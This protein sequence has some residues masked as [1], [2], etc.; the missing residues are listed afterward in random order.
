MKS[1]VSLTV[2]C[3]L[4]TAAFGGFCL[5]QDAGNAPVRMK[6]LILSTDGS[7]PGV[8]AM[9]YL[10]DRLGTPYDL[11][12]LTQRP[13][14]PLE[15]GDVGLYQGIILATGNLGVCDPNCHSALTV[16]QWAGMDAYM[17]KY[18]VRAV[19]YFTW[20]ELRYGLTFTGAQYYTSASP[21]MAKFTDAAGSVFSDLRRNQ[22]VEI[23][24]AYVYRA[25]P[26]AMEGETT[27]PILTLGNDVLAVVH[28]ANNGKR[29]YLALTFDNN[30]YLYHSQLLHYGLINWVT[31]G[32]FLGER[33]AYLTPQTD[34]FFLPNDLFDKDVPEC[35]PVGFATDPTFD[36]APYCETWRMTNADLEELYSWQQRKRRSSQFSDF[37]I[38]LAFN[39]F[40]TTE[41]GG[42]TKNDVL[43]AAA[44]KHAGDFYWI[45]HTY[46]HESLDC[47]DAT[48]GQPCRPAT[49][50]ESTFEIAQNFQIGDQVGL[51]MDRSSMVTPAI[52][53][54]ANPDFLAAARDQGLRYL[55]SDL[56]RPEGQ[57]TQPNTAIVSP[58]EPSIVYIPRH[59][60]N[61]YY[62]V[63][64]SKTNT[65]GSITDEYNFF[66]GPNGY[67]KLPDGSP[68][69]TSASTYQQIIDRESDNIIGYMLQYEMYPLMFH[70]SNH[71][72]YSGRKTLFTD[73][74]D[75]VMVKYSQLMQIPVISTKQSDLGELLKDRKA[76]LD[77]NAEAVL[78]PG[79]RIEITV[80]NN[81]AKVPI[82]GICAD[83]CESYGS[84]H[85][86][87]VVVSPGSAK[88]VSVN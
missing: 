49:Y 87:H 41:D 25:Q 79:S 29:E 66:Y 15:A 53:G 31:R 68:F 26:V 77:S 76:Y 30:Y 60:T 56:S 37:Q 18:G 22:A 12:K 88:T 63:T 52:S 32:L 7:E 83:G 48:I 28:T 35:R 39:G 43:T 65:A 13:M 55:V 11:V 1:I 33:K 38:T 75:S 67:F 14:P 58:Y 70:Q 50:L 5:A 85:H 64:T 82:T 71:F 47:F 81:E 57:P 24:E 17:E 69:F 6:L 2:F 42:A 34:D 74:L 54:L 86:S 59:A 16:E 40:G 84:E 62:N 21:A 4:F 44:T 73:V 8:E 61:I 46:D 19:S 51:V 23:K 36:A 78:Y 3:L 27:T 9:T 10:L 80:S 72:R 20:P 45:N